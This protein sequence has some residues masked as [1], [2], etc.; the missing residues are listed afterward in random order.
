MLRIGAPDLSELSDLSDLSDKA[1]PLS[2]CP[3][4]GSNR[5]TLSINEAVAY[6][7]N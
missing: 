6:A 3:K 5:I 2:Y 7:V 4:E 1:P